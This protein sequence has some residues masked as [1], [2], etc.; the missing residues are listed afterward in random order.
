MEDD[1]KFI[2]GF[3]DGYILSKYE[4]LLANS[5]GKT[6]EKSDNYTEGLIEGIEMHGREITDKNIQEF[7]DLREPPSQEKDIER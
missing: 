7:K 5:I 3:N 2:K 6:V 4:S 1:K